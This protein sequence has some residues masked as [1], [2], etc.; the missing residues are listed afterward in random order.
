MAAMDL[1]TLIPHTVTPSGVGI[2]QAWAPEAYVVSLRLLSPCCGAEMIYKD[3]TG[4]SMVCTGGCRKIIRRFSGINTAD[5]RWG[6]DK[7]MNQ[8]FPMTND[9]KSRKSAVAWVER[10]TGLTNLTLEIE[11]E[12]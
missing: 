4:P 1:V 10:W 9:E 7:P 3:S 5:L 2:A 12:G 6:D 8:W 11:I